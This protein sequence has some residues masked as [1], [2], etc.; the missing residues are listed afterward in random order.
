MKILLYI[1]A[2]RFQKEKSLYSF[3]LFKQSSNHNS[4]PTTISVARLALIKLRIWRFPDY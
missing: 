3:L 1:L 2:D 4:H